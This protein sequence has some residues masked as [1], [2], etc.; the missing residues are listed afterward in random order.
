MLSGADFVH[1]VGLRETD[2]FKDCLV[3]FYLRS[4]IS[5]RSSLYLHYIIKLS[6]VLCTPGV[7]FILSGTNS[8]SGRLYRFVQIWYLNTNLEILIS[9]LNETLVWKMFSYTIRIW[10]SHLDILFS[11]FSQFPPKEIKTNFYLFLLNKISTILVKNTYEFRENIKKL[12][13]EGNSRTDCPNRVPNMFLEQS[14]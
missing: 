12:S 3:L 5:Y 13:I 2:F 8:L 9:F 4:M 11:N 7:G 10:Y 1:P 6:Y 14:Y